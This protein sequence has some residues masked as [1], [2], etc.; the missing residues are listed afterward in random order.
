MKNN[1][2]KRLNLAAVS[3]AMLL[4]GAVTVSA[5]EVNVGTGVKVESGGSQTSVNASATGTVQS[6]NKPATSTPRSTTSLVV[7]SLLSIANRD[8]GIGAEVRLVAREQASTSAKVKEDMDDLNSES[9]VKVFFFGPDYK[10]LGE[11]RSTIV[12]T[13]NH[14]AR[15]EKVQNRAVSTSVKADLQVQIEALKAQASSTQAFIDANESKLS[16]LGWFVRIFS[17]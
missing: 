16:L 14:I 3:L 10:N 4:V 1:T 2:H 13:E 15:L 5:V 12:T 9:K 6:Q 17:K 8:G 11:L 7:K